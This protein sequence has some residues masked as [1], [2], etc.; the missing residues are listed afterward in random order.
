MPAAVLAKLNQLGGK[1]GIAR[2][3]LVESRYVGMRSRGCYETPGV[4][5][6]RIAL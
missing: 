4:F 1:C 2:L 5:L 6:N 3:D